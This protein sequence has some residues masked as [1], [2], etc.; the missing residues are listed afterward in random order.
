MKNHFLERCDL[1]SCLKQKTA[2]S[3]TSFPQN[4]SLLDPCSNRAKSEGVWQQY[5]WA[6]YNDQTAKVTLTCG[7]VRESPPKNTL[8]SGLGIIL[9]CHNLPRIWGVSQQCWVNNFDSWVNNFDR[10]VNNFDSWVNNFPLRSCFSTFRRNIYFPGIE[11][12]YG[13][14]QE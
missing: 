7:F 2:T 12:T 5:G 1:F 6:N 11:L 14:F 4:G 13:C 3:P 9:I 8:N 10:W